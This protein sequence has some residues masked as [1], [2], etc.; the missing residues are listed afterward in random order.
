MRN[1]ARLSFWFSPKL[2]DKIQNGEPGFEA[3]E[4]VGGENRSEDRDTGK[5]QLPPREVCCELDEYE[6]GAVASEA[7]KAHGVLRNYHTHK[8]SNSFN[9]QFAI[10]F[11]VLI[12]TCQFKSY[13]YVHAHAKWTC[14]RHTL[15]IRTPNILFII[16]F[17]LYHTGN[18]RNLPLI[19]PQDVN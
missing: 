14:V 4:E 2:W 10:P 8:S 12:C 17:P 7:K 3:K 18:S 19:T 15:R 6:R 13:W 11:S 9:E 5:I 16:Y 1:P